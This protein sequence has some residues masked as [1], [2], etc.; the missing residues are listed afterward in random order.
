MVGDWD[1]CLEEPKPSWASFSD[2]KDEDGEPTLLPESSDFKEKLKLWNTA[3][4]KCSGYFLQYLNE[5]DADHCE[6][7]TA[8]DIEMYLRTKYCSDKEQSGLHVGV[9][10]V[11][12]TA[13]T[14]DDNHDKAMSKINAIINACDVLN[15]VKMNG[16]R[17]FSFSEEAK[18]AFI[19]DLLPDSCSILKQAWLEKDISKESYTLS[20]LKGSVRT[21][22]ETVKPK[23][24]QIQQIKSTR[25]GSQGTEPSS[26]SEQVKLYG[27]YC[28]ACEKRHFRN[29]PKCKAGKAP[30]DA[31]Q[32]K[33]LD[34]LSKTLQETML[35]LNARRPE[36]TD[37]SAKITELPSSSQSDRGPDFFGM[38]ML[39]LPVMLLTSDE[40]TKYTHT[41]DS[42]ANICFYSSKDYFYGLVK[43]SKPIPLGIAYRSEGKQAFAV[44][45]G[46]LRIPM[47]T[48]PR[49]YLSIPDAYYCPDISYNL[50]SEGRLDLLGYKIIR[51]DRMTSFMTEGKIF[52]TFHMRSDGLYHKDIPPAQVSPVAK[53]KVSVSSLLNPTTDSVGALVAKNV[54]AN[55][56][57]TFQPSFVSPTFHKSIG[58][59][60]D[61]Q[62]WHDRLGHLSMKGLS[63][64]SEQI[65]GMPKFSAKLELPFC[66]PCALGK[67]KR[68]AA[69]N[70]SVATIVGTSELLQV[71]HTDVCGPFTESIGGAFYFITFT[72]DN[73][74]YT[75]VYFLRKKSEA[76]SAFKK[77]LPA[78]ERFTSRKLLC[79]KLDAGG[80]YLGPF[81]KFCTDHGIACNPVAADHPN[82]NGL[83]ERVNLTLCDKY[84]AML[85]KCRLPNRFWAEAVREANHIKNKSPTTRLPRHM[86][87][88]ERWVGSRPDTSSFRVFGCVAYAHLDKKAR[89]DKLDTKSVKCINIGYYEDHRQWRL[90]KPT[91]K[92]IIL[93]RDVKFDEVSFIP[94][95]QDSITSTTEYRQKVPQSINMAIDKDQRAVQGNRDGLHALFTWTDI[96]DIIPTV[97]REAL[98]LVSGETHRMLL[99]NTEW[100]ECVDTPIKDPSTYAQAMAG[101]NAA[102]WKAAMDVEIQ[103]M[104]KMGVFRIVDIPKDKKCI[105]CRY[106]YTT[107]YDDAG[108]L[109]KRKARLVAQGFSQ[110]EGVDY[111]ETYSGVARKE[112]HRLIFA[113]AA[114][115]D[116]ELFVI[117]FDT[118]FLNPNMD[119]VLYMRF[120]PGMANLPGKCLE[121]LKGLYGT[122]QGAMLW[123]KDLK[124]GLS[125]LGWRQLKTDKYVFTDIKSN[126][127]SI[128]VDDLMLAL[129]GSAE[130]KLNVRQGVCSLFKAKDLGRATF[131][132]GMN[133]NQ[134]LP[135]RTIKISA[136]TYILQTL[137]RYK[138]SNC[139]SVEV[140]MLPAGRVSKEDCP[141]TSSPEFNEMKQY[142]FRELVATLAWIQM[143][144]RPDIAYAVSEHAKVQSNPALQ[145]WAGLKRILRYLAGTIDTGLL[146]DG[147]K[148]NTLLGFADADWAGDRDSRRSTTGWTFT[149]AK[150]AVTWCS[151][152]QPTISLSSCEA[153]YMAMGDASKEAIWLHAL[154]CELRNLPASAVPLV[155]HN[156]NK[157]AIELTKNPTSHARTKHIDIRFHFIRSLVSESKISISFIG[158]RKMIA[159]IL[160]KPLS[161]ELFTNCRN[162]MGLS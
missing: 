101:P 126:M 50:I 36:E 146:Y 88:W 131:Y 47:P 91:S 9:H 97:D 92:R 29:D 78:V 66:K 105:G 70:R 15:K 86:T 160:T 30:W 76:L 161:H 89:Q 51:G 59:V 7:L 120:P 144:C 93:S 72:D 57:P 64:L 157:G 108:N 65:P 121:I 8:F 31:T 84:L 6:G 154:L 49:G 159:D 25:P 26:V 40:C 99:T 52:V 46:E 54:L 132:L 41:L 81:K 111:L 85:A 125:D 12:S 73:S 61:A 69:I 90:Y 14:N 5:E 34:A 18:V 102:E 63:L 162:A 106:V 75:A 94:L 143:I 115:E 20:R 104:I 10:T 80:E 138:M 37:T 67:S 43:L 119:V 17:I 77:Y 27:P 3:N 100:V 150:A 16:H 68:A 11:R 19:V 98:E 145:H 147:R 58:N 107:K 137:A 23:N 151:K 152:L 95:S 139:N 55:K 62:R 1:F 87:P 123:S 140:P 128:H 21:F 4:R 56:A 22:Y 148:S 42:G 153:E 2:V 133:I 109:V 96:P 158:T 136:R 71:V 35:L 24:R 60:K 103:N 135:A 124:K 155:L 83:A 13:I 53:S 44:A 118:A 129:R 45:T 117:D 48:L 114:S 149:Y 113:I 116:L 28:K 134:D 74:S 110:K 130:E 38:L 127:L 79:L 156:D 82:L 33:R 32:A 39:R 112:S 122:K 142:P 141:D